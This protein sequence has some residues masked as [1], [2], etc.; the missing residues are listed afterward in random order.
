MSGDRIE[1]GGANSGVWP[2]PIMAP[3]A[4]LPLVAWP[5]TAAVSA[6]LS[7]GPTYSSSPVSGSMLAV[8]CELAT[9]A[10]TRRSVVLP[11]SFRSMAE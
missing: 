6:W 11:T 8:S 9:G 3:D 4:C 5:L 10:A 7:E 2:A 1:V